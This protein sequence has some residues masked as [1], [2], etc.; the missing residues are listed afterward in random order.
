MADAGL[1]EFSVYAEDRGFA[2]PTSARTLQILTGVAPYEVTGA[3]GS[4][5]RTFRPELTDCNDRSSTCSTS[6]PAFPA[7]ARKRR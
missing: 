3:H 5:R 6:P 7:L 4:A 1:D 2:A